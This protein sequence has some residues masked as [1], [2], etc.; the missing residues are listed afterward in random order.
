[1]V[2]FI[3]IYILLISVGMGLLELPTFASF[4]YHLGV[5]LAHLTGSLIHLFDAN[6]VVEEAVL[7]QPNGGFALEVTRECLG[8]ESNLFYSSALLAWNTR[9][10][11]KAA[12]LVIGIL[13]IQLVNI[14][15]LISLIYIGQWF[16]DNFIWVHEN[17]WPLVFAVFVVLLFIYWLILIQPRQSKEQTCD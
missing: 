11:Y 4:Y 12:G 17:L 9:W 7:R 2:R 14:I 5:L 8:L 1:M 15:R 10:Q 13:L 3:V 16:H 6:I